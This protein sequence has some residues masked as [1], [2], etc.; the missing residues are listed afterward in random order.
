MKFSIDAPVQDPVLPGEIDLHI[1]FRPFS[2]LGLAVAALLHLA[3]LYLVLHQH[4]LKKKGDAAANQTVV[5]L[6]D[7]AKPLQLPKARQPAHPT[8]SIAPSRQATTQPAPP[9]ELPATVTPPVE[10]PQQDMMAMLQAARARRQAADDA[11]RAE[12]DAAAQAAR[13]PSSQE[14]AQANVRRSLANGREGTGGVFQILSKSTRMASFSFRGWKPSAMNSFKQV[15]EVDAGLGGNVEL[16]IIRRMIVLIRTHYSGDF[17]WDSRRL[18]RV[19]ILSAR[20]QDNDALE[21][22]MMREFFGNT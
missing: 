10:E 1:R 4:V 3:V 8:P 11:A 15:I 12:N 13:G 6:L 7:K 17:R 19:V 22:F 9:Q 2:L 18:G 16:A 21:T 14:I 5:L 20:P